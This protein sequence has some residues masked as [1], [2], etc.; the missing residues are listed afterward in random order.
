MLVSCKVSGSEMGGASQPLS[1]TLSFG[2]IP[3][4][5]VPGKLQR[6]DWL[7][8]TRSLE[9]HSGHT[10]KIKIIAFF[11]QSQR[12][13]SP[14]T[15]NHENSPHVSVSDSRGNDIKYT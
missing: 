7:T 8:R 14:L 11:D 12:C 6:C 5:D 4:F 15:S 2:E 9:S 3:W 13:N 1:L 10:R